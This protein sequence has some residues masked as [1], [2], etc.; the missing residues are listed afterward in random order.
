MCEQLPCNVKEAVNSTVIHSGNTSVR[1][2]SHNR[3]ESKVRHATRVTKTSHVS[4]PLWC[5]SVNG[6]SQTPV[7]DTPTSINNRFSVLSHIDTIDIDQS[8]VLK[9]NNG[10]K[11]E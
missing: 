6:N 3:S 2:N 4:K 7:C 1:T 10:E 5:K 11:V 8:H 9:N